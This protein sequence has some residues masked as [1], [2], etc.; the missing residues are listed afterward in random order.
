[1]VG[2]FTVFGVRLFQLQKIRKQ[3]F[4]QTNKKWLL[5]ETILK[6]VSNNY[7]TEILLSN[8]LFKPDKFKVGRVIGFIPDKAVKLDIYALK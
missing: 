4:K 7:K 1:M 5:E 6:E 8:S 2:V 3:R